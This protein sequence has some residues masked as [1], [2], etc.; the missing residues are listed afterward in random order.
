MI[1]GLS[2]SSR[3]HL[4]A[5]VVSRHDE[6]VDVR[7]PVRALSAR[8]RSVQPHAIE[9]VAVFLLECGDQAIEEISLPLVQCGVGQ[10]RHATDG[11]AAPAARSSPEC[12][13][14]A[15]Q[16]TD[17]LAEQGAQRLSELL[18]RSRR[19][20]QPS[21]TAQPVLD[22][23]L[24]LEHGAALRR[25]A[26]TGPQRGCGLRLA[27][28]HGATRR[29]LG[30]IDLELPSLVDHVDPRYVLRNGDRVDTRSR[31]AG[32]ATAATAASRRHRDDTP[33]RRRRKLVSRR[34]DT[35]ARTG[36]VG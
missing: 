19:R 13:T 18:R 8:A 16:L 24:A 12:A 14:E 22:R 9:V 10:G 2:S 4:V 15:D 23:L 17:R 32:H 30:L 3:T 28:P 27:D 7:L 33:V 6:E 26:L 34:H 11:K 20:S 5:A 1:R 29:A 21:E 31:R 25:A 36:I 35:R